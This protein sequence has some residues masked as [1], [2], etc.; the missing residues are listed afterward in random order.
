MSLLRRKKSKSQG[1]Q[2]HINTPEEDSRQY[3]FAYSSRKSDDEIQLGRKQNTK[4]KPSYLFGN[5]WFQRLGLFILLIAIIASVI[6]IISLSPNAQ[7]LQDS[8]ENKSPLFNPADYSGLVNRILSESVW[9]RNK[10]T[11]DTNKISRELKA[12]Y[13]EIQ[14]VS[15]DLP[16]LGHNPVV[17]IQPVQLGLVLQSST[18]GA[19]ILDGTGRATIKSSDT[20]E[21]AQRLSLPTVVDYSGIEVKL[22]KQVL[23]ANYITFTE[24]VKGELEA[25]HYTVETMTLPPSSGELD[26]KIVGQPYIIKFNL[27][28]N[29]P[30][31][32]AGTFL[33]TINDLTKQNTPPAKYVDVRVDGRA[34]YQ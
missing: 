21:I 31:Q 25:K 32:Q 3:G 18:S 29:D 4:R 10:I 13:P 17:Y 30:Q 6:N 12:N 1:R 2:R 11:I 33:A 5:I 27:A 16:L 22:G 15:V 28:N 7:I 9:N 26:V 23:P 24:I 20:P 19:Y 8:G 14:S 34:Y